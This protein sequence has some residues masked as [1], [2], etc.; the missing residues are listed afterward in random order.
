MPSWCPAR[1]LCAGKCWR[2]TAISPAARSR[3][4]SRRQRPADAVSLLIDLFG[5]LSIVLHGLTI[6]AQSMMLG[7]V[8]FLVFLARPLG[9]DVGMAGGSIQAGTARIAAW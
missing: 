8:L 3:S 1:S 5:Y 7:G 4:P 6:T 9:A 2:S